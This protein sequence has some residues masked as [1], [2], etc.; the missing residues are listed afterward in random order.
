MWDPVNQRVYLPTEAAVMTA[1]P[2]ATAQPA[3]T[4]PIEPPKPAG[5]PKNT[6][7]AKLKA[8][9]EITRKQISR[10]LRTKG[11]EN[12]LVDELEATLRPALF[13]DVDRERLLGLAE[14]KESVSRDKIEILKNAIDQLDAYGVSNKLDEMEVGRDQYP[15]VIERIALSKV[16]RELAEAGLQSS[17]KTRQAALRLGAAATRAG[18]PRDVLRPV[19]QQLEAF[20]RIYEEL[21]EPDLGTEEY[22]LAAVTPDTIFTV[23]RWRG[24]A[25]SF[26]TLLAPETLLLP[27]S[28][29]GTTAASKLTIGTATAWELGLPICGS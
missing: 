25:S 14:R 16:Y 2:A 11:F 9:P 23:V 24:F 6:F 7:V 17:T 1:S 5:P 12:F 15:G 20:S 10:E 18:L 4:K 3:A 8:P 13:S 19:T 26:P 29:R 27:L 21:D 22:D 28:G